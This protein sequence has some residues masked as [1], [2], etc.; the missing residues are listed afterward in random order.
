MVV[1]VVAIWLRAGYVSLGSYIVYPVFCQDWI[2]TPPA[3]VDFSNCH[4]PQALAREIYTTDL[5]NKRVIESSPDNA[6]IYELTSCTIVGIDTWKCEGGG[7]MV[8]ARSRNTDR[9]VA[10]GLT[11]VVFATEA[12]WSSINNGIPSK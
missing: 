1:A 7:S 6:D 8:G 2:K 12:Q 11:A 9:F 10:Y 3:V 4:Q 5:T